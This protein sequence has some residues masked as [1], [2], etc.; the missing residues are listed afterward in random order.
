MLEFEWDDTKAL[1]NEKKH[2][3]SFIEAMSIFSDPLELTMLDPEHSKEEFRFLSIGRSAQG[4]LLVVSYTE[5]QPAAIRLIS[6][7][8]ATRHERKQYEQ[9]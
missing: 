7:R 5:R 9:A 4:H 8:P 3:I 1:I 2:G 6:A